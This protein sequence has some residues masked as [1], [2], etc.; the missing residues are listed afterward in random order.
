MIKVPVS[1]IIPARNA[2]RTLP[3][4]LRALAGQ[5]LAQ[6]RFEVI[7]VDDGSTDETAAVAAEHGARVVQIANVGP[8]SARNQGVE[9][10]EGSILVFTD[11]DCAP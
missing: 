8:A 4:C 5:T 11:A 2:A 9:A 6:G 1:V 3:S 10:A 7:V